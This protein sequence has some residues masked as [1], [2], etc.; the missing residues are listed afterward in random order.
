MVF[1]AHKRTSIVVN[2]AEVQLTKKEQKRGVWPP[3]LL[4][5]G[6]ILE[7]RTAADIQ[8]QIF[9]TVHE[10]LLRFLLLSA[11]FLKLTASALIF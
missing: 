10:R 11:G 8:M 5:A 1:E 9:C 6:A 3:F 7:C 4:L 2:A